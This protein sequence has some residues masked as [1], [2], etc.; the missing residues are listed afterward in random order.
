[1]F[2]VLL[3]LLIAYNIVLCVIGFVIGVSVFIE[4]HEECM[5]GFESCKYFPIIIDKRVIV[6]MMKVIK[7][8]FVT[9]L[10]LF[11][12]YLGAILG[13]QL[14]CLIVFIPKLVPMLDELV[15]KKFMGGK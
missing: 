6:D 7:K 15:Y 4:D 3:F 1:M 14:C 11:A 8:K 2:Y 10:L 9:F 13:L 12:F 5:K